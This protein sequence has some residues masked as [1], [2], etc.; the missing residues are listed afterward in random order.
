M[1]EPVTSADGKKHCG[2]SSKSSARRGVFVPEALRASPTA[3]LST[4]F[5]DYGDVPFV[6]DSAMIKHADSKNT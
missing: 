3:K 2:L 6:A 4:A 1:A 5:P